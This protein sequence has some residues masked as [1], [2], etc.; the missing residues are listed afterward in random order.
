M[1]EK[2]T[3]QKHELKVVELKQI[4]LLSGSC[5]TQ[6]SDGGGCDYD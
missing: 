2:K 1:A 5:N 6:C 4:N 3:F